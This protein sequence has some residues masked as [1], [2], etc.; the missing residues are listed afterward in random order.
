MKLQETKAHSIIVA[1]S[2]SDLKKK[3]S[4]LESM[5][6][7]KDEELVTVMEREKD[8]NLQIAQ[9]KMELHCEIQNRDL[10]LQNVKR[11]MEVLRTDLEEYE[12][13]KK[14]T[15]SAKVESLQDHNLK[16]VE[17]VS[18]VHLL[19]TKE[20]EKRHTNLCKPP[21]VFYCLL[22]SLL[23]D[24]LNVLLNPFIHYFYSEDFFLGNFVLDTS[25]VT[26]C[27]NN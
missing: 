15:S 22:Q 16:L 17:K 2:E 13:G 24:S 3:V 12:S 26:Y 11:D 20:V 9:T 21:I 7:S 6:R 8:T 23:R 1:T 19:V 5:I 14:S 25:L 10:E 27:T 4:D 18:T